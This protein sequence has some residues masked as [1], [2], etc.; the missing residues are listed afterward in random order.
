M[1]APIGHIEPHAPLLKIPSND[2]LLYKMMTAENLL[3][4]I[5]GRYLHFN[6]VDSYVDFPG[7]DPCDGQQTPKD[8]Q[9]SNGIKFDKSPDFSAADYYN[10]SRSRTYACCFSLENSEFIWNNYDDNSAI[11]KVCI[12]FNFGKLRECL[13]KTLQSNNAA[14][15]Y[16]G[17][18]CRQIFS[19]NYG[20]V[21]Y[22]DWKEHQVCKERLPNP[23]LYT[24][25]KD[26]IYSSERELRISLSAPGIGQFVLW[27]GSAIEFPN[28]FQLLF[29][30]KAAQSGGIIQQLLYAP[31]CNLDIL[32]T[33][34]LKHGI[35]AVQE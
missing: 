33:E 8:H 15:V 31:D 35:E 17:N 12:V 19:L 14:L 26:T 4:S 21:Q 1:K 34:L 27:D 28:S 2:Q 24:Y 22:V 23:I 10:Q 3:R 20:I 32:R 9:I 11:G 13:N 7:A 6:R 16:N 5:D 30:F 25:L 29:D 18:Q